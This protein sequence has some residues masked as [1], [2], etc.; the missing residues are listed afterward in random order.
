M[1][2]DARFTS[3]IVG[4]EPY[5]QWMYLDLVRPVVREKEVSVT[6]R[7]DESRLADRQMGIQ[8]DPRLEQGVYDQEWQKAIRLWQQGQ[9]ETILISSWNEYYERTEI[10]PHFDAT[11]IDKNPY[12][13]YDKTK[14]Y[15]AQLRQSTLI[16]DEELAFTPNLS[17]TSS[18]QTFSI[19]SIPEVPFAPTIYALL[20]AFTTV[21]L[22]FR[23]RYR[24]T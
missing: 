6:P 8:V 2:L 21:I 7:Y 18:E 12:F 17:S 14:D 20:I 10:E 15:I 1:P 13:L 22:A 9:V 3:R 23:N 4:E 11:A 24:A 16:P 19:S 5:T